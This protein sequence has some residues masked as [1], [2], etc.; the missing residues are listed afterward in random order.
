MAWGN[1][2]SYLPTAIGQV[3]DKVAPKQQPAPA[4]PTPQFGNQ[5]PNMA[6]PGRNGYTPTTAPYGMDQSNPG[7]N[8]QFWNQ[9]QNLW[10]QGLQGPG[11]GQ[12]FWNQVQ[13]SFNKTQEDKTPQFNQYYDQARDNAVG[14]MNQQA[15][16]RG[17]YGSSAALNGVGNTINQFEGQRGKAMTDFMMQ[18][19][20]RK[21]QALGQ[22]GNLAFGAGNERMGEDRAQLGRLNDAFSASGAAQ[23]MREQ[24]TQGAFNNNMSYLDRVLGMTQPG[25]SNM[26]NNDQDLYMGAYDAGVAKTADQSGYR[27]QTNSRVMND[28]KNAFDIGAGIYDRTGGRKPPGR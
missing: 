14:A 20:Q 13:G 15:S 1:A 10:Q 23:N 28:A 6:T 8:E 2:A 18:D 12:Q 9:N 17:A 5:M 22:Y 16:S 3:K 26:I 21:M 11:Q 4:A 25:Y 27:Q 19:E 7:V 24:R